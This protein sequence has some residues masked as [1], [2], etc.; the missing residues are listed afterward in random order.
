MKEEKTCKVKICDWNIKGVC[1]NR[2]PY[3]YTPL[4]RSPIIKRCF[5]AIVR[6]EG[7]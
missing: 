1:I 2:N 5:S 6:M 3:I 4:S 7:E